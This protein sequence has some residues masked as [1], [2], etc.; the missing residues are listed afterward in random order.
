MIVAKRHP[1]VSETESFGL[2]NLFC[3]HFSISVLSHAELELLM[4]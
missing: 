4:A 2:Q 1:S 3:D